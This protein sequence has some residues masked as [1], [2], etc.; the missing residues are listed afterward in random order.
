LRRRATR[1]AKQP[2]KSDGQNFELLFNG[3]TSY[4]ELPTLKYGGD[5]CTIEAIV[6]PTP[7]KGTRVNPETHGYAHYM[8]IVADTEFGGIE[9]SVAPDQL[10]LDVRSEAQGGYVQASRPCLPFVYSRMHVAAVVDDAEIRLYQNGKLVA[11]SEFEHPV[12]VSPF[13]LRIGCSPH[14]VTECHEMF[15][16]RIDEVR[17]S[18]V[19]RYADDFEPQP[20]FKVDDETVALY[21]FDEG[22]GDQLRDASGNG[23]HGIIHDARWVRVGD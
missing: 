5:A 11:K 13:T 20:Q 9:L 10:S 14:P 16:G 7:I 12:A 4:V 21:H 2:V 22:H 23:H 8:A 15:C 18:N 17:I 3:V 1:A 19:V 6:S